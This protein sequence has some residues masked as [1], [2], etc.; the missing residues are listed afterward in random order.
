MMTR[1][2]F[3]PLAGVVLLASCEH[4]PDLSFVD[5]IQQAVIRKCSYVPSIK[6][7]LTLL[8]VHPNW[9]N[10]ADI[11]D[12]ICAVVPQPR[13][14]RAFPQEVSPAPVLDNVPITGWFVGSP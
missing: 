8:N 12:R 13:G 3:G 7:I 4:M 1:R 14:P 10:A 9:T 11:A 5:S 2:L 6:A